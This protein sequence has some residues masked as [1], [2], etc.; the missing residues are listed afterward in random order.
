MIWFQSDLLNIKSGRVT[1]R[2]FGYFTGESDGKYQDR[3]PI[4]LLRTDESS[5]PMVRARQGSKVLI[6]EESSTGKLVKSSRRPI[7]AS[8]RENKR[9][10]KAK[11]R[12]PPF[13]V[14]AL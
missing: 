10:V 5:S 2:K 3:N 8:I 9:H 12:S 4:K 13:L 1:T 7:R 11:Q 6:L 14:F